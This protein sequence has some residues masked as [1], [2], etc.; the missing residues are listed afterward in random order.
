M[1]GQSD[2]V[3]ALA[4]I[5]VIVLIGAG[6]YALMVW[7]PQYGVY[8]QEQLGKAEK[9]RADY[10]RQIA[11]VEAQAKEEAAKAL[12]QAEINR[13]EGVAKANAIIGE[14]L[15][16]NE[17]YLRYLWIMGMQTNEMQVV[18]VPTEANLPILEA[19]RFDSLGK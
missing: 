17:A 8:Q 3:A 13:A 10:N 7:L 5:F 19:T 15:K 4:V 12:A 18:Y 6:I 16:G 2:M 1:K 14:S 9:A 11:I